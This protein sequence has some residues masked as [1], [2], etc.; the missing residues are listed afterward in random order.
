MSIKMTDK[1]DNLFMVA[2]MRGYWRGYCDCYHAPKKLSLA[3]RVADVK[4]KGAKALEA[5]KND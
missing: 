4:K 1:E 5:F 2:F 3:K